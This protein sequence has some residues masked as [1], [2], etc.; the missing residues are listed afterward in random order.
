M[1]RMNMGG[2]AVTV[3]FKHLRTETEKRTGKGGITECEIRMYPGNNTKQDDYV[4]LATGGASCQAT[5]PF[6]FEKGRRRALTRAMLGTAY[7]IM[8]RHGV[9]KSDRTTTATLDREQRTAIWQTY[10]Q[11]KTGS[12]QRQEQMQAAGA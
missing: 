2:R 4:V 1:I 12:C 3:S 9:A 7:F 8:H 5:D 10:W 6:C 11:Q